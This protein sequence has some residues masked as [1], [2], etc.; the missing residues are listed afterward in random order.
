MSKSIRTVVLIIPSPFWSSLSLSPVLSLLTC[1]PF[2]ETPNWRTLWWQ[3]L[4]RLVNEGS[5]I[6]QRCRDNPGTISSMNKIKIFTTWKLRVIFYLTGIFK[7]S[8]PGSSILSNLG[9]TSLR[10]W[11]GETGYMEVL[12]QRAGSQ[13]IVINLGKKHVLI[14]HKNNFYFNK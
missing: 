2:S 6:W 1:F 14:T 8:S 5:M 13:R 11:W 12:Q 4:Q 10:K 3:M 7:T 9:R